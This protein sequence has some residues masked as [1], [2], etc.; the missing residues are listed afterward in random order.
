M[1]W[2]LRR[3]NRSVTMGLLQEHGERTLEVIII[4]RL[5]HLNNSYLYGNI[6]KGG[7]V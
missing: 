3:V 7:F 2:G 6:G 1:S 5:E 4:T